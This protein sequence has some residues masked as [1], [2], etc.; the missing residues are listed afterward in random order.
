[1]TPGSCQGSNATQDN[2]AAALSSQAATVVA[3]QGDSYCHMYRWLAF[4]NVLQICLD[5]AMIWVG[6]VGDTLGTVH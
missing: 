3:V 5:F 2:V 1:M 4:T 6:V